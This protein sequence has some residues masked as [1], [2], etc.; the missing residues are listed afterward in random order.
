[1]N[2]WVALVLAILTEVAAT[3]ALKSAGEG[4]VPATA[5]VVAGYLA[6]FVLLAVVLRSIEVGTTYAIWAGAGTALVATI[7]IVALGEAVS[8]AKLAS[9]ALIIAGVIGLN[10]A[11]AH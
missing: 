3:V 9:L 2:A 8:F 5:V 4:S 7:G 6:S 1:M 11:G 10:L